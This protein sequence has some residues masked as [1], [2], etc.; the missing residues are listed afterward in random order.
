MS[1]QHNVQPSSSTTFRTCSASRRHEALPWRY[2]TQGSSAKV[3]ADGLPL[4]ALQ[5]HVLTLINYSEV[6]SH[7]S[8]LAAS[9]PPHISERRRSQLLDIVFGARRPD[10]QF[11]NLAV[12]LARL[13][14]PL[15]QRPFQHPARPSGVLGLPKTV[16]V[17]ASANC[18]VSVAPSSKS[19][20]T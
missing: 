19:L 2:N 20:T 17:A 9:E 14:R 7:N 16:V 10:D 6:A 3:R 1:T 4:R 13:A 8:L 18:S 5:F 15:R 12:G 11:H